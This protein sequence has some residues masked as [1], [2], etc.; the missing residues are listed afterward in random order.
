MCHHTRVF[1]R[2]RAR[3]AFGVWWLRH[4][5]E[6]SPYLEFLSFNTTTIS[7][8][9]NSCTRPPHTNLPIP[10]KNSSIRA[11]M[12]DKLMDTE[13]GGERQN[14]YEG[15]HTFVEPHAKEAG[16]LGGMTSS[17]SLSTCNY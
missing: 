2:C 8:N 5:M 10:T 6:L 11:N 16:Q 12:S 15:V 17:L 4:S 9:P 3:L 13:P 1:W 14:Q 7:H